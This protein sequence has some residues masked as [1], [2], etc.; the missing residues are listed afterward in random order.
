MNVLVYNWEKFQRSK[1]RYLIFTVVFASILLLS[2]LTNNIVWAILLFFLLW[3]YFYYSTINN[4]VVTMSIDENQLSI[5]NK[6]Y[7]LAIFRWY[8]LEIYPKT[9]ALKNIVLLTAK[10][11]MI[12]TFDDSLQNISVFL[13]TVD[14]VLPLLDTYDQGTFEKMSRKMKL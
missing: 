1:V 13:R 5:G 8:V 14:K 9:Q 4:Q 10:W 6:R 12:Y 3:W 7:D 11:H 2:L